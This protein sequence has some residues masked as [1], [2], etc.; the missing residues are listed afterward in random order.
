MVGG[1]RGSFL[2]FAQEIR[3]VPLV[4]GVHELGGWP[5]LLVGV[6][7]GCVLVSV[8]VTV[9]SVWV[10]LVGLGVVFAGLGVIC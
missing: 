1:G 7:L 9:S 6:V 4:L 2:L 8:S 5:L 10:S 3:E